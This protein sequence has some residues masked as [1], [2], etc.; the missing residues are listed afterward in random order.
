MSLP[1]HPISGLHYLVCIPSGWGAYVDYGT[2]YRELAQ[3]TPW[4]TVVD[5]DEYLA[6]GWDLVKDDPD[7]CVVHWTPEYAPRPHRC[8]VMTLYAEAIGEPH[9]MLDGHIAHWNRVGERAPDWDAILVHT[10]GMIEPLRRGMNLPTYVFPAGWWPGWGTPRWSTPRE[11]HLLYWGSTV[12]RRTELIPWLAEHAPPTLRDVS[13]AFG[14]GILAEV[15]RSKAAIYIAH[16]IVQTFS[17]WRLWQMVST[18]T[19]LIAEPGESWPFIAGAH[20][21][22]IPY[23]GQSEESRETVHQQILAYY[24][25]VPALDGV[26]HRAFDELAHKYTVDRCIE[27]FLVPASIKVREAVPR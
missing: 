26:A 5:F 24:N 2:A 22:P 15:E 16:S 21:L 12:G 11:D 14:R 7:A 25:D 3:R 10:P 23:M 6:H 27:D 4:M 8:I 9:L 17:T 20:Y 13:G 18:A 1:R 19:A